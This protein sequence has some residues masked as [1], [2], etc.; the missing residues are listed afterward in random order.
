MTDKRGFQKLSQLLKKM[1]KSALRVRRAQNMVEQ[2]AYV[3]A[4]MQRLKGVDE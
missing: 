3:W 4:L 2:A 1:M